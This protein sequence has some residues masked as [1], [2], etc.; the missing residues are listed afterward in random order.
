M[1][2]TVNADE[3]K[4]VKKDISL[5]R[6][7]KLHPRLRS[8]A[9]LIFRLINESILKGRAKVRFTHTLRTKQEQNELYALG[10]TKK[11]DIV[12]NAKGGDSF[13]NYGLAID[14][15]L[16]LDDKEAS[17]DDKTDFDKDGIADWSEVV[18]VFKQYGWEWGGDWHFKDKPHFQK[19]F[20]R[21]ITDLKKISLLEEGIYPQIF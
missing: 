15:C 11:G 10:R 14:I 18:A 6:I 9:L 13:H 1:A 17:W 4:E 21:S 8:E 3:K 20:G 5:S 16:I 12:T 7:E 2:K 19:T